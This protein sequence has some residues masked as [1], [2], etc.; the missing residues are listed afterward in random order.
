MGAV[1]HGCKVGS[2]L[3]KNTYVTSLDHHLVPRLQILALLRHR[4][5]SSPAAIRCLSI[6]QSAMAPLPVN[7]MRLTLRKRFSELAAYL[8][9]TLG[10][11]GLEGGLNS[12]S[13]RSASDDPAALF[14]GE[15]FSGLYIL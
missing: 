7:R 14:E 13:E 9:S 4:Y 3:R 15:A 11:V 8:R 2:G 5:P 10:V 6:A 1:Q 12:S